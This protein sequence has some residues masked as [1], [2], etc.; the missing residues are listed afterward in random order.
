MHDATQPAYPSYSWLAFRIISHDKPVLFSNHIQSRCHMVGFAAR[1]SQFVR[2]IVRGSEKRWQMNTGAVNF[3][4]RDG[5]QHT[6]LLSQEPA[7]EMPVFLIPDAHLRECLD[8]EHCGSP[9]EMRQHTFHDDATL[10]WCLRR[11]AR[12][13]PPST[14]DPAM[15]SEETAR[16]L[17]LRLFELC[18]GGK[19]PWHADTSV[20]ARRTMLDLVDF[21]DAHLQAAPSLSH[22]AALVRWPATPARGCITRLE[23]HSGRRRGPASAAVAD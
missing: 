19:P 23:G 14:D 2:W 12:P 17:V 13:R 1:G 6:F 11:L 16:Q 21:I 8:T 5:E 7:F 20:F 9:A 4:P 10:Q 3:Y 22:M 18:T 15:R